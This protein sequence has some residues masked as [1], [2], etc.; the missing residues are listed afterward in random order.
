MNE[1]LARAFGA[2]NAK[3]SNLEIAVITITREQSML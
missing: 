2:G 3:G 1:K